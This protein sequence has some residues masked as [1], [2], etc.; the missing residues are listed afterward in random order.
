MPGE[1]S[2]HDANDEFT[3]RLCILLSGLREATSKHVISATLAYLIISQNGTR[4]TFFMILGIS[5]SL[6]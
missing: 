1:R 4:L 2:A 5:L 3:K 6:N